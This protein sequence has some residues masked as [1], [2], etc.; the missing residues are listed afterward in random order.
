MIVQTELN[1]QKVIDIANDILSGFQNDIIQIQN[2]LSNLQTSDSNQNLEIAQIQNDLNLIESDI[3]NL[4]TSDTNQNL[5]LTQITNDIIQ[6]QS[7]IVD[8]ETRIQNLENN[9]PIS[10]EDLSNVQT[11][12]I[13]NGQILSY[14]NGIWK[15][16]NVPNT[17]I[18]DVVDSQNYI[19]SLNSWILLSDTLEYTSLLNLATITSNLLGTVINEQTTQNT[20]LNN[21]ESLFPIQL[22]LNDLLDVNSDSVTLGQYLYFDGVNWIPQT[23]N[24]LTN[25]ENL[26]DVLITNPKIDKDILQWNQTNS[27]WENKQISIPQVLNDLSDVTI[28]SIQQNQMI[29]YD[30]ISQS[31]INSD[32]YQYSLN[33]LTNY[34]T[35]ITP[36]NQDYLT[37]NQTSNKWEPKTIEQETPS[38]MRIIQTADNIVINT[39]VDSGFN[40]FNLFQLALTNHSVV[41]VGTDIS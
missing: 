14:D 21:L 5:Q 24:I 22:N 20:R 1:E 34:E 41:F 19:R 12:S 32:K 3:S 30:S 35:S 26:Q 15:N 8:H 6:I 28:N 36:Q 10:V 2:D 38:Y 18:Q 13:T 37:F 39:T 27:K 33:E 11:T 4:Q 17:G 31:F 25:L 7:E 16:I 9:F 40:K 29:R 23:L